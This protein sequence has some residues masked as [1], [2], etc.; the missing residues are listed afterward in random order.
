M[1]ARP[2]RY[3]TQKVARWREM[4]LYASEPNALRHKVSR[5]AGSAAVTVAIVLTIAYMAGGIGA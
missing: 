2:E 3:S 4:A 5:A 1:E